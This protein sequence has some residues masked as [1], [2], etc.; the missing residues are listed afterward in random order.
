MELSGV[1]FSSKQSPFY[2]AGIRVMICPSSAKR[3]FQTGMEVL[4][5]GLIG[6]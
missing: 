4:R 1:L 6:N 3:M 2:P 5:K